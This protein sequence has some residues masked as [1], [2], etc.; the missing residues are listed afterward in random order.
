[1]P[2]VSGALAGLSLFAGLSPVCESGIQCVFYDSF[3]RSL[4]VPYAYQCCAFWGCDSYANLNTDDNSLQ[5]HSVTKEK[6][7]CVHSENRGLPKALINLSYIIKDL[8]EI[9]E[10]SGIYCVT[11]IK[12]E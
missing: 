3:P 4:S 6:G 1:M 7:K 9:C 11:F 10:E 12:K 5:D 8:N 2:G